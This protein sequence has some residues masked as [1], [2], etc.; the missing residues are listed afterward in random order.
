MIFCLS[1]CH[2]E[3]RSYPTDK[4]MGHYDSTTKI[5]KHLPDK[6]FLDHY[7]SKHFVEPSSYD[8]VTSMLRPTTT[9]IRF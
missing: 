8:H 7:Q 2:I 6:T 4:P 1:L 5:G 9:A 3:V